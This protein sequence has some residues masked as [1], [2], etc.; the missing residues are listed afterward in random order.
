MWLGEAKLS[1]PR[2]LSQ[3]ERSVCTAS[4][5]LWYWWSTRSSCVSTDMSTRCLA[6]A[7]DDAHAPQRR[8]SGTPSRRR[9]VYMSHLAN[10]CHLRCDVRR[11]LRRR[12]G[13]RSLHRMILRV[14]TQDCCLHALQMRAHPFHRK[15]L[16]TTLDRVEDREVV[17]MVRLARAEDAENEAL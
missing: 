5:T 15:R 11:L 17:L 6:F 12:E 9:R 10:H 8:R 16:V 13:R 7:C 2:S 4:S 1:G 14:P 3:L